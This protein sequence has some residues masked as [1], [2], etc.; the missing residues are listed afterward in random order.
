MIIS[1]TNEIQGHSVTEHCGLVTGVSVKTRNEVIS[2]IANWAAKFG[3]E[4]RAYDTL[5]AAARDTAM[6][7]L[8]A[9]AAALG[10]NA[11]LAVRL[12]LSSLQLNGEDAVEAV[13]YG[14]AVVLD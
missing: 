4:A 13:L 12:D 14:T 11:I 7:Q 5:V 1:T 6:T 9:N 2:T 3:G 10:A 8:T